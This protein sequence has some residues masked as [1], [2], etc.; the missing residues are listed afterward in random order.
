MDPSP[1]QKTRRTQDPVGVDSSNPRRRMM[2]TRIM[3]RAMT[4]MMTRMK[5]TAMMMMMMTMHVLFLQ[6]WTLHGDIC[7]HR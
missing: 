3:R 7:I 6:L 2:V 1:R 5:M 4:T